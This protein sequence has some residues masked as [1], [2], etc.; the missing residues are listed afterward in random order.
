MRGELI[1][2]LS[3]MHLINGT[4]AVEL[5]TALAQSQQWGAPCGKRNCASLR[6]D[7]EVLDWLASGRLDGKVEPAPR[8]FD[9]QV[10]GFDSLR[11]GVQPGYGSCPRRLNQ[12]TIHGD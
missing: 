4:A 8:D 12:R 6:I 9:P 11:A 2:A 7:F 1:A 5:R 10:A 3:A